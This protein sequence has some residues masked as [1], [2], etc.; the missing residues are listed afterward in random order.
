MDPDLSNEH[1]KVVDFFSLN[2]RTT[3]RSIL[4]LTPLFPPNPFL[5][6]YFTFL[7]TLFSDTYCFGVE[8]ILNLPFNDD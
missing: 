7:K 2:F 5:G 4:T 3:G 6:L 1:M 8:L